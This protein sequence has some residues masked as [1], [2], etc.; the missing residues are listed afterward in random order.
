MKH[1]KKKNIGIIFDLLLKE[2][3]SC[4]DDSRKII[5]ENIILRFFNSSSLLLK[6][7]TLYNVLSSVRGMN[8][9]DSER[10]LSIIKEEYKKLDHEKNDKQLSLLKEELSSLFGKSFYDS[11]ISN[12]KIYATIYGVLNET[13]ENSIERFELENK[14][15]DL[16]RGEDVQRKMYVLEHLDIIVYNQY[17]RKF[18]EKYKTLK[19]SQIKLLNKYISCMNDDVD[20]VLEINEEL[21]KCKNVLSEKIKTENDSLLVEKINKTLEEVKLFENKKKI[22]GEDFEFILGL[23]EICQ[24][25]ETK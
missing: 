8:D 11:F 25:L 9:R 24:M 3:V 20:F 23:Q 15:L 16:M 19:E 17:V 4:S 21:K 1:N 18:N 5:I 6:E 22:I 10:F 12:Y 13:Y 7:Y 14:V 2:Y